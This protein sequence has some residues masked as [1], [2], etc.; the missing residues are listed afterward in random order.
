VTL[1]AHHW[2]EPHLPDGCSQP[3]RAPSGCVRLSTH[4]GAGM[5]QLTKGTPRLRINIKAM[6]KKPMVASCRRG[7]NYGN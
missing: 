6:R 7:Y 4:P 1:P 3:S 2:Q 5:R